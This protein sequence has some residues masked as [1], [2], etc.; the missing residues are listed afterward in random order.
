MCLAPQGGDRGLPDQA[1]SG[2]GKRTMIQWPPA[3]FRSCRVRSV[4]PT[5]KMAQ[6]IA[7]VLRFAKYHPQVIGQKPAFH[8]R[9]RTEDAGDTG[10]LTRIK[11]IPPPT[12]GKGP[13]PEFCLRLFPRKA[14]FRHDRNGQ[15]RPVY[16]AEAKNAFSRYNQETYYSQALTIDNSSLNDSLKLVSSVLLRIRP[17]PWISY[18]D[19]AMVP[20]RSCPGS[21]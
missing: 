2:K 15:S 3:P 8:R 14:S 19:Q 21:R 11:M 20:G 6:R 5:R 1:E 17:P 12:G 4:R 13:G 18:Q 10:N 7:C 16:V 9:A